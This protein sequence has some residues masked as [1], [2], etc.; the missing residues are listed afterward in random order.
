MGSNIVLVT[1][2]N[3]GA[4]KTQICAPTP[5]VSGCVVLVVMKVEAGWKICISNKFA[6]M[7]LFGEHILRPTEIYC[8]KN[9]RKKGTDLKYSLE[10][11][12]KRHADLPTLGKIRTKCIPMKLE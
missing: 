9:L 6:M 12:L 10:I 2:I 1:R 7:L 8:G 3:W 11:A 5:S 4:V